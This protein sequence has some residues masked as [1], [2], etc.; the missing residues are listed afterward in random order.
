MDDRNTLDGMFIPEPCPASWEGMTG[1]DRVRSCAEC[2]QQVYNLTAMSP[3]DADVLLL[4]RGH[5]LCGRAFRRPDGTLTSEESDIRASAPSAFQFTIRSFMAV[6]AG[7]AAI[8]GAARLFGQQEEPTPPPPTTR[9]N[10]LVM[11]KMMPQ[12][13]SGERHSASE[14]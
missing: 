12:R 1:D 6:V 8:L 4:A 13:V 9:L 5:E 14:Y 11:G 2:G 3:A 10:Q 7:V